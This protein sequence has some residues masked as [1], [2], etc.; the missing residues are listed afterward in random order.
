MIFVI[1]CQHVNLIAFNI[2]TLQNKHFYLAYSFSNYLASLLLGL[3]E[4]QSSI[5][6]NSY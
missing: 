2:Y 1:F 4:L 6:C 5:I 3:A